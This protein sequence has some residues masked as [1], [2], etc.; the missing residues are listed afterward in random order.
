MQTS[1]YRT[2]FID[3]KILVLKQNR[4]LIIHWYTNNKSLFTRQLKIDTYLLQ[5]LYAVIF[6]WAI[7]I[8]TLL[9]KDIKMKHINSFCIGNYD[10]EKV[11][12]YARKRFI[13]GSNMIDLFKQANSHRERQE[14]SLVSIL[15]TNDTR[16]NKISLSCPY[17][18]Q[19]KATDCL[20]RIKERIENKLH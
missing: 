8:F 2:L 5:T 15:A 10:F 3:P 18:E 11:A 19:C 16:V 13:D 20:V 12:Y 9:N 7:D 1:V 6:C 14:M 17:K 4:N